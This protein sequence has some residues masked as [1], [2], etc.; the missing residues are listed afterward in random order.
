MI[1][2]KSIDGQIRKIESKSDSKIFYDFEFWAESDEE[3][4]GLVCLIQ[5]SHPTNLFITEMSADE[6]AISSEAKMLEVVKNRVSQQTGVP[7]LV[8]PKV[9]RFDEKKG[10]VKAGFQAFLKSYEKPIPVYES[11]FDQSKEAI[12]IEK[13]SIDEFKGLGGKIHLLG[14]ISM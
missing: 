11:I 3:T 7:G 12:Q 1:S 10:D 5:I 9:I 13:L 2:T 6:L 14:N 8:F 4:Y